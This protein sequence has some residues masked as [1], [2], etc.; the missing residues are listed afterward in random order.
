MSVNE[1]YLCT[2]NCQLMRVMCVQ[3]IVSWRGLSVYTELSD[4]K[5]YISTESCHSTRLMCVQRSVSWRGLCVYG[6][7]SV[8]EVYVCMENF[9]LTRFM[10][11]QRGVVDEVYVCTE[12]CQLT[13]F[14]YVQRVVSWPGLC[15]NRELSVDKVRRVQRVVSWRQLYRSVQKGRNWHLGKTEKTGFKVLRSSSHDTFGFFFAVGVQILF[16]AN[17][18]FFLHFL[19]KSILFLWTQFDLNAKFIT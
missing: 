9:Q 11:V 3:R 1:V 12:S 19:L 10:C 14:M 18:V 15:V 2:E 8:G 17:R 5:V 7:F 6:E 13:R 4:D 16:V